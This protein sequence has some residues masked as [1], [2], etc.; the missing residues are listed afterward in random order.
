ML[1]KEKH[2]VCSSPS[3][4][5]ISL[6]VCLECSTPCLLTLLHPLRSGSNA[7]LMVKLS[8]CTSIHSLLCVLK[9]LQLYS[10]FGTSHSK[11]SFFFF[12]N[13]HYSFH[14]FIYM[15]YFHFANC[16]YRHSS[17]PFP[18]LS[19]CMSKCFLAPSTVSGP[20]RH[21]SLTSQYQPQGV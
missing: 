17:W 14:F 20:S 2:Y 9:M 7:R 16:L 19:S 21:Q 10:C 8:T 4:L 11:L 6:A 15:W 13:V 18:L 1:G 12:F 5:Y 3:W